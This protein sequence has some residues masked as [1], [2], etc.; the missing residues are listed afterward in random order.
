MKKGNFLM[1]LLI[2]SM[3]LPVSHLANAQSGYEESPGLEEIIVTA[4]KRD[5]G[6]F[7]IPVSVS[8]MTGG[9]LKRAGINNPEELSDFV[10]GLDFQASGSSDGRGNPSIRFRGMVQQ[11]ITPSTQIGALFWD[12]SYVGG[13]GGFL[14]FA[15]VERVE[16]IKGPQT[17]Q[18]GRNTFSGAVNIIPRLPGEVWEGNASLEYSGS[19]EDNYRLEAGIGGPLNDIFGLRVYAGQQKDGGD[20]KTQDGE[21]YAVFEDTTFSGTLTINPSDALSMKLTGYYVTADHSGTSVGVDSGLWGTPAGECEGTYTGEYVNIVTGEKTPFTQ[22]FS[23]L[24]FATFCGKYPTGRHLSTPVTL[25]PTLAQ[26]A[27]GQAGLD[28][29]NNLNP[30]VASE[31]IFRSPPGALGGRDRTYHVNFSGDYQFAEHTLSFLTSYANTGTI[32]R[33]DLWFG[34]PN[35]PG[36]VNIAGDDIAI[37]ENYYE[38]RMTSSQDRRLRYMF[39]VSDYAQRYHKGS[40][41]GSIDLEDNT[42]TAIFGSIDYDLTDVLTLSAELRYTDEGT[43]VKAEGNPTKACVQDGGSLICD[44]V[45]KHT[46]YIPRVILSYQPFEGVTTYASYSYSSLLGVPTQCVSV[47]ASRPDLIDPAD[48][49]TIGNFTPPQENTQYELGWK[50]RGNLWAFTAAVYYIDWKNQPFAQIVILKDGTT[51]FRGPGSSKYQGID[52]EFSLAPVEWLDISGGLGYVDAE[53][54]NFSSRG[55]NESEVLG[56]GLNSVVSDG[57]EPRNVP[58][59]TGSLSPTITG[60]YEGRE[61]FIRADLIYNSKSWTDYSE[62]DRAPS[63]TLLNLRAGISPSDKYRVEI[64]GRNLTQETAFGPDS[65]QT[66]TGPGR[67]RKAFA[68]PYQRREFGFRVSVDF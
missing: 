68:K 50:Q 18:F 45:N 37:R 12:G 16:V 56:S 4:R 31:G 8:A 35:I 25:R 7:E 58:A 53:M 11:T 43:H 66:T 52:L 55:S 23:T 62:V 21:A 54:T 29:L 64:Y 51:S 47:A 59:L 1:S 6:I 57:K 10:P 36:T 28:A 13:G 5:E 60:E 22:D 46:D 33:R 42:T 14:P 32:N 41:N 34:V 24:P 40:V 2:G 30:Y 20:F 61:W 15:D 39:G 44:E 17:A 26:S 27:N 3:T 65:L 49:A 9:Q 48:C 38:A 67:D 19:Q 63:Q